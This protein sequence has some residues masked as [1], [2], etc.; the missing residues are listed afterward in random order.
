MGSQTVVAYT[1]LS[2]LV[3]EVSVI[4]VKLDQAMTMIAAVESGEARTQTIK[5]GDDQ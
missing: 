1:D 3:D 4:E 2:A 5:D